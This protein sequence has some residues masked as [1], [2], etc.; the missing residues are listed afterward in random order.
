[1]K[2]TVPRL[3]CN[4]RTKKDSLRAQP[5]NVIRTRQHHTVSQGDIEF[6][7]INSDCVIVSVEFIHTSLTARYH[8]AMTGAWKLF[9]D[10][11]VKE[12]SARRA[13]LRV[14]LDFALFAGAVWFFRKHGNMLAL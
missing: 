3:V 1:M 11:E 8:I 10:A 7:L 4:L 14:L 12:P 9:I 2:A 6:T 5:T 13:N